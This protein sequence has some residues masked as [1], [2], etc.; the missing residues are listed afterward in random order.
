[1]P[2]NDDE[3]T[4]FKSLQ[5]QVGEQANALAGLLTLLDAVNGRL[6]AVELRIGQVASDTDKRFTDIAAAVNN[7]VG[8]LTSALDGLR[9]TT[10]PGL[11][12]DIAKAND[13]IAAIS[14]RVVILETPTFSDIAIQSTGGDVHGRLSELERRAGISYVPVAVPDAE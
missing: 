1:M 5:T 8:S 14:A 7:S 10:V 2:M 4:A 3:A 6:D 9:N 13:D 12:G 11:F